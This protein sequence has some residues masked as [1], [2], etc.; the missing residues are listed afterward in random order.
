M[1]LELSRQ[2][3]EKY[4]N[5][6][7]HK[8]PPSGSRVV[9]RGRTDI[10]KLIVAFRNFAIALKTNDQTFMGN[11]R[12]D[13]PRNNERKVPVIPTVLTIV[14]VNTAMVT[15]AFYLWFKFY[16]QSSLP[17]IRQANPILSLKSRDIFCPLH[18]GAQT[19]HPGNTV[20]R[21]NII[22]TRDNKHA[23]P[24]LLFS[25][26]RY[27]PTYFLTYLLTYSMEQSPS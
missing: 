23:L 6:N 5:I 9:T 4:A 12:D 15:S 24:Y 25:S 3:F 14:L 11:V 18:F 13:I 21:N 10:T 16:R 20:T 2:F 22:Q 8:N 7:F 17:P 19:K 27:L 1:K 26:N